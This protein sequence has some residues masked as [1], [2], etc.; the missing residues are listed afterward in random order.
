MATEQRNVAR[1]E[2]LID[3]GFGAQKAGDILI[4]AFARSG[5]YVYIEP[6]IPAE[7]SPPPRTR[8][9]LS[10]VIVRV[11]D[12]DITNIGNNTDLMLAAH[13]VVLDR[14]LDDQETNPHAIVLL[15][16]GDREKNQESY[17]KIC[18]RV[19]QLGISMIT[20]ET[21]AASLAIIRS[22]GGSGK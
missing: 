13:E 7:I 1:F 10:G 15:D 17:D 9:A 3:A 18:K 20:F 4:K 2:L 5:K 12:F 14:R 22:L 6:M 21:D 19:T 11:A 16:T 8:P